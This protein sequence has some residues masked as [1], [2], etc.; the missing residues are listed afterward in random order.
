MTSGTFFC[1]QLYSQNSARHLGGSVDESPSLAR[2]GAQGIGSKAGRPPFA[3]SRHTGA[4]WSELGTRGFVLPLRGGWP[5]PPALSDLK[6]HSDRWDPTALG[7]SLTF[8]PRPDP[9][10]EDPRSHLSRSSCHV[11]IRGRCGGTRTGQPS[12]LFCFTSMFK[13]C[14]F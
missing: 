10:D 12:R 8:W 6:T 13:R 3:H 9:P 5:Q 2:E 14:H 11:G 1:G 7:P 4:T